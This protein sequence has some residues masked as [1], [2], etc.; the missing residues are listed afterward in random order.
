MK[1]RKRFLKL[2]ARK[3][4]KLGYEVKSG[5]GRLMI[6][7]DDKRFMASLWNANGSRD[8]RVLFQEDFSLEGMDK[9]QA[10]GV[11]YMVSECNNHN[12]HTTMHVL[13][14]TFSCSMSTVVRSTGDFVREFEFASQQIDHVIDELK[15][16]YPM[17]QKRFVEMPKER[18]IGFLVDRFPTEETPNPCKLVAQK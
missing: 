2:A 12:K 10:V 15:D 6:N 4:G 16:N 17:F 5:N 18:P 8:C 11:F 1:R 7:K 9:I 13:D 3:L 14:D